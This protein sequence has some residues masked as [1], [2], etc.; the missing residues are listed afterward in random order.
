MPKIKTHK[1]SAKRFKVT[2][3]KKRKYM[4]RKATQA[5]FNARADGSA[6]RLK[7]RDKEIQSSDA[8][9]LKVLIPYK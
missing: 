4:R 2:G 3:G 1:A 5:H 9:R 7:R 8:K 6:V